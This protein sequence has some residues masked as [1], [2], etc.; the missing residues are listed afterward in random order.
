M[1]VPPLRCLEFFSGIGGLHYGFLGSG[2]A[3]EV[4]ASFDINTHANQTYAL[5][6]GMRPI[7]V[8]PT[9]S[10]IASQDYS[11]TEFSPLDSFFRL[12]K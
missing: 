5:N 9:L 2:V 8:I 1:E 7:E 11:L 3:G 12:R 6:F 4:V 10:P